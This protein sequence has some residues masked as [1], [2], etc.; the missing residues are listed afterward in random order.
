MFKEIP[1]KFI[2][3]YLANRKDSVTYENNNKLFI[4]NERLE[5]CQL[6]L[7]NG[8]TKQVLHYEG[9]SAIQVIREFEFHFEWFAPR[10]DCAVDTIFDVNKKEFG[11]KYYA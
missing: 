9:D 3:K 4:F 5:M 2:N 10:I 1:Q 11:A 6:V 7:K 8:K